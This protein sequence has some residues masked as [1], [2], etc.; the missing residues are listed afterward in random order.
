MTRA[1]L[2][3]PPVPASAARARRFVDDTLRGWGCDGFVDA[4]RLLVS[5]LVTNGVL[6]AR[7]DME[8]VLTVVRGDLRAEVHDSSPAP[9]VVRHYEDEAMTGRGLGL[10]DQ[11]ADR[12][13][14]DA[15]EGGKVVWFEL[16][17]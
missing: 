6:H 7:T 12:W 2:A 5:E 17:R 16:D 1:R 11:L 15:V 10:L 8:L 9:P 13:G 3:L 14:V 4:A